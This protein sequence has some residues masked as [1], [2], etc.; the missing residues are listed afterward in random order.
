MNRPIEGSVRARYGAGDAAANVWSW[1]LFSSTITKTCLIGGRAEAGAARASAP[2]RTAARASPRIRASFRK[3]S[4]PVALKLLNLV[5][6]EQFAPDHHALDL[7]RALADQEQRSVAV[8]ALDLVLLRVAVA[9]VDA[10]RVLH[11]LLAGLR[12]EQLRHAGLEVRALARVLEPRR[13]Q[14]EQPG[15]VDLRGHVGE[16][17]LDRL[18]LRDWLA[19]RLAL[20]RVAES[21]LQRT[22]RDPH[23]A[24]GHVHTADLERVH[25]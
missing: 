16:L 23:A 10:E 14:R 7:G 5:A 17:E 18:V 2:A 24:G 4:L 21:Q 22:L 15:G 1:S 25:H 11:D 3:A 13:A 12:G 8:E 6:L 20:L 9:A 19:E